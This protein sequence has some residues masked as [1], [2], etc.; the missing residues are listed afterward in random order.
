M[1]WSPATVIERELKPLDVRTDPQTRLN[2]WVLIITTLD[3]FTLLERINGRNWIVY[4]NL[5]FVSYK[6]DQ[7]FFFQIIPY[8]KHWRKY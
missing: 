6:K 2:W 5:M 1:V 4:F 3:F 8:K 7:F